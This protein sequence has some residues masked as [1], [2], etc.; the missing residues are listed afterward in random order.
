MQAEVKQA[1][2]VDVINQWAA[3]VTK[4]L[5]KQAIPPGNK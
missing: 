2:S 5:I 4:G 1:E 3:K